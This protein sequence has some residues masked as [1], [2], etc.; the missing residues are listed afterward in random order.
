MR[1]E[2][3]RVSR[4]VGESIL[5]RMCGGCRGGVGYLLEDK[6]MYCG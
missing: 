3:I 4:Q 5:I 1:Y 2:V 6:Y